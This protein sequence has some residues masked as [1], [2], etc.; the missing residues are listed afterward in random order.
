MFRNIEKFPLCDKKK[1]FHK[2][3]IITVNK[4]NLEILPLNSDIQ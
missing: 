4:Q 1:K 3:C 2:F